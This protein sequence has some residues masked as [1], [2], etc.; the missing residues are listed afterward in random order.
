MDSKIQDVDSHQLLSAWLKKV[1]TGKQLCF[2]AEMY[3]KVA[4]QEQM[5]APDDMLLKAIKQL[6]T[7][8]AQSN[9]AAANL[10]CSKQ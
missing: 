7:Y 6:Q 10:C 3:K 2:I 5:F 8:V 1:D 4:E 9:K